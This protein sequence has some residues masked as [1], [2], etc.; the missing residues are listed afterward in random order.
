MNKQEAVQLLTIIN[1]VYPA[2]DN[3]KDQMRMKVD[4][5]SSVFADIPY[6]AVADALKDHMKLST[7]KFAPV[8]GELMAR[9]MSRHKGDFLSTDEAWAMVDKAI[10]NST[11][12]AQEEFERFPDCIK[13]A[14]G[15]SSRLQT[16]AGMEPGDLN[17]YV[18]RDFRKSYEKNIADLDEERVITGQLMAP[19][20]K[21]LIAD[22]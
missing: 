9:I 16:W 11:Y 15:S 18:I 14:V 2:Q 19:Q 10:K 6:Q 21:R 17:R 4:V 1:S 5:W 13:K 3:S 12:H 22:G 7:S 8:P 20:N